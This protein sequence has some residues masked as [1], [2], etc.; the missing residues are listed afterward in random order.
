VHPPDLTLNPAIEHI[1]P[2]EFYRGKEAIAAGYQAAQEKLAE[3]KALL[4]P[5][6]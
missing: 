3:L 6:R 2:L 4:R 1:G 5:E